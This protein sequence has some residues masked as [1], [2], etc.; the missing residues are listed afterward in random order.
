MVKGRTT[1]RGF[2]GDRLVARVTRTKSGRFVVQVH[3]AALSQPFTTLSTARVA[4]AEAGQTG[5]DD[6]PADLPL[7][8]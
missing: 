5:A 6:A 1:F 2:D 4:A 7:S 3:G 8:A